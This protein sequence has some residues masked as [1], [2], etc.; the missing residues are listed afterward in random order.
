MKLLVKQDTG[1][2]EV[3]NKRIIEKISISYAEF[4]TITDENQILKSLLNP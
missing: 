4:V 1:L 2:L 3:G